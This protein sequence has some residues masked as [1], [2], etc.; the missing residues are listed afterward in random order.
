[1]DQ[2]P[3]RRPPRLERVFTRRTR[4]LFF[5][6][7]CT[8]DRRRLLDCEEVHAAFVSFAALS[9]ERAQVWVGRY[10]IMPDHLHVFVSAEGSSALQRWV[11][12]LKRHLTWTLKALGLPSPHWQQGFFDHLLRSSES[13]GEKW[14]YVEQNPV[15]AGLVEASATWPFAGEIERL[16]F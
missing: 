14:A 1:M 13:Y 11:A 7:F 5:L 2:S 16:D 3:L 8:Q 4:P 9:P 15:R 6:T 12:S 10:V